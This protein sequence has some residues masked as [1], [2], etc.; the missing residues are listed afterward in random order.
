MIRTAATVLITLLLAAPVAAA[1]ELTP[2]ERNALITAYLAGNLE[3]LARITTDPSDPAH[4]LPLAI[5]EHWWRD[6]GASART[7]LDTLITAATGLDKRRLQWLQSPEGSFPMPADGERD[8]WG[9]IAALVI[10]RQMREGAA[11]YDWATDGPLHALSSAMH[12]AKDAKQLDELEG[13]QLEWVDHG[14]DD[15]SLV[16]HGAPKTEAEKAQLAEAKSIAS[17]NRL[18][19]LLALLGLV[20]IP[21]LVGRRVRPSA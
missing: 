7:K 12:A 3:N 2:Q 21:I 19:A 6:G 13:Y 20:V 4:A 9:V 10:D 18:L 1:E 16:Y 14:R 11:D 15:L 8:S 17:R 5:F